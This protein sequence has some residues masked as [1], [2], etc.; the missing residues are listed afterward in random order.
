MASI[1]IVGCGYYVPEKVLTNSDLERMV[2]TTSEWIESKVGIRERRVSDID[3]KSSDLGLKAALKALEHAKL[4]PLDL[5]LIVLATSSP[6]VI[7]PST[8]S[9]L[10]GK[11]GA[12]NS[13]AFDVSAVCAG[14]V[15]AV[16]VAHSMMATYPHRYRRALV[17]GAETYSKILDWSDRNTCVFFGDGAGAVILGPVEEGLG[18][19][20][21]FLRNDGR[22]A[23]VIRFEGDEVKASP[24]NPFPKR[25]K[26]FSMQG[27]KVWDFATTA[28]PEAVRQVLKG[29]GLEPSDLDCIISHQ[30]NINI[31]KISL[32]AL[33]LDMSSTYTNLERYGNTS[34]ASIPIA[35]AEAFLA[36]RL[37]SGDD[38]VLVGF[39]GGL[40]Y[41]AVRLKWSLPR[42]V[43]AQ[44]SRRVADLLPAALSL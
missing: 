25:A 15:Y 44:R 14:F 41:G 9:I 16:S 2:D 23:E 4:S 13:A 22:G 31:I 27:R 21:A 43:Q 28:M 11:L 6:D 39:G 34:G 8:A 42:P 1:G 26:G 18:L 37:D 12:L 17:L 19:Q 7:Q 40:S 5:D 30:A 32:E 33:G 29:S 10:Q 20:D 36:G 35:L 38:V 24:E 3:Q